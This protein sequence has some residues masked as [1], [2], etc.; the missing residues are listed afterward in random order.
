MNTRI[1]YDLA[2][3]RGVWLWYVQCEASV[4]TF[5]LQQVFD[6]TVRLKQL[7]DTARGRRQRLAV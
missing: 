4:A 3:T 6:V 5:F 2:W 1:A 7:D